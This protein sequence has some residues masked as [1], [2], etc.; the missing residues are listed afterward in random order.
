[1]FQNYYI[2]YDVHRSSHLKKGLYYP[3]FKSH[4][5]FKPDKI[6]RPL[7]LLK[8]LSIKTT[9]H[10]LMKSGRFLIKAVGGRPS[11]DRMTN[12]DTDYSTP[13]SPPS[14]NGRGLIMM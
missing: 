4:A 7:W 3:Q 6:I 9:K 11:G 10:I 5:N 8:K 14:L 13:P 12:Q 1:M 2:L